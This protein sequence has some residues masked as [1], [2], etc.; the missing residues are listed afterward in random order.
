MAIA[1]AAPIGAQAAPARPWMNKALSA[2]QRARL[3]LKAMTRA[4]K[5]RSS[6]VISG[7]ISN[8]RN[9][10][11]VPARCR[12]PPVTCRACPTRHY[13]AMG[14]RR[15][16]RRRHPGRRQGQAAAYR[17]ALGAGDRR[18]L[19][20][21][22]SP[23]PADAMIGSEAR[24]SGF[25]VQLAGGVNLLRDPRNGRNF[26]YGGEDPL[27]AGTI[28][29]AADCRHPVE[30]HHLDDQALRDER[31]GD[32]ALLPSMRRSIRRRR[33][34]PT[35]SRSSSRSSAAIPVRSCAPTI[36][37]TAPMRARMTGC[38]TRCCKRD[39]GFTG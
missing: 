14:N 5:L 35:C 37:S 8:P 29:G 26:E 2:D 13:A 12:A 1:V 23:M 22:R 27:L 17:A 6:W 20:S 10:C 33:E 34:C 25:N 32:R 28:V 24:A 16:R 39:F 21:G 4:E 30:P 15:R 19:E 36:A 7:P 31:P 18:D 9:I 11:A 38:S 3:A